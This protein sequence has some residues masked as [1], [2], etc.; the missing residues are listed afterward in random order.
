MTRGL[1]ILGLMVMGTIQL[2]L[3]LRLERET[4]VADRLRIG[5]L[6]VVRMGVH[7]ARYGCGLTGSRVT[8]LHRRVDWGAGPY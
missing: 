6:G 7:V 2:T 5:L 1:G 4:Q 8:L 3:R